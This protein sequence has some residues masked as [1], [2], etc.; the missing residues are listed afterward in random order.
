MLEVPLGTRTGDVI[1]EIGGGVPEGHTL[2]A[3][4]PGGPLAGIMGPSG[5]DLPLE[6]EEFRPT[7]TL[8]GG[9]GIV[10][11]DDRACIVDLCIYFEWF[12]EDESCGRCTTCHGGTQRLVEIFRRISRGE[13]KLTDLNLMQLLADSLRWSNCVHGQAS[14]TPVLNSLKNFRDELLTHIVEKRCP[15]QVCHGLIRYEVDPAHDG[16]VEAGAAICPTQAI[17]SENGHYFIDQDLCIKCGACR[18]QNPDAIRVLDF[19]AEPSAATVG[20][21][22]DD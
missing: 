17:K 6:P 1:N 20:A 12:C 4:Q 15:A 13:G 16:D 22:A 7:G 5:M 10:V 8:M 9:G 11:C 21:A 14:P 19:L 2:K 3:L 18:E